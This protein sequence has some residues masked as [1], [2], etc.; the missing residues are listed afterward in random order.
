MEQKVFEANNK[1]SQDQSEEA[2][3]LNKEFSNDID[4][5]FI[6]IL[7]QEGKII[8]G[9]NLMFF[10]IEMK[11]QDFEDKKYELHLNSPSQPDNQKSIL[12][13]MM[14]PVTSEVIKEEPVENSDHLDASSQARNPKS[15]REAVYSSDT[16]KYYENRPIFKGSLADSAVLMN[17]DMNDD[18]KST[19]FLGN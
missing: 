13:K 17:S 14:E 15:K 7:N 3:G 5:K 4:S 16:T 10:I 12:D 19:I 9:N 8:L 1:D 18:K 2:G 11:V 6:E